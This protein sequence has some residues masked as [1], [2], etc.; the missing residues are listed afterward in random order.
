MPIRIIIN[1]GGNK[2]RTLR[3]DPGD[4]LVG[5]H[6]DCRLR[7]PSGEV[8]RRHCVLRVKNDRLIVLD[9]DSANGTLLNGHF[10]EGKEEAVPGDEIQV[11]PI[12]MVVDYKPSMAT[13]QTKVDAP[14]RSTP[15]EPKAKSPVSS[16]QPT[17]P[18]KRGRLR[19][20]EDLFIAD[21]V[22]EE[23]GLVPA[24][25]DVIV[26]GVELVDDHT[27]PVRLP[28]KGNLRDLLHGLE[29]DSNQPLK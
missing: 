6:E 18:H 14:E 23:E 11:G 10:I 2:R 16:N 3:L 20:S 19:E 21:L 25:S 13:G 9:L 27:E 24:N 1:T 29:D 22:E 15:L 17:E 26:E 12:T 7:I 8:S 28:R 4:T 5:R